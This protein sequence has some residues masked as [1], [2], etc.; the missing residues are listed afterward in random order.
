M[1]LLIP[2]NW[3]KL[4]GHKYRGIIEVLRREWRVII[5]GLADKKCFSGQRGR[6]KMNKYTKQEGYGTSNSISKFM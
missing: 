6:S 3:N 1:R 4:L 2:A 5:G